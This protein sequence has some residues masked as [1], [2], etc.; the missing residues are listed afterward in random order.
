MKDGGN[1]SLHNPLGKN[2]HVLNEWLR[3]FKEQCRTNG[4]TIIDYI[5]HLEGEKKTVL[6]ELDEDKEIIRSFKDEYGEEWRKLGEDWWR[7][8]LL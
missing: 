6:R 2:L 3:Y 7:G 4:I 1:Y 5:D 8:F